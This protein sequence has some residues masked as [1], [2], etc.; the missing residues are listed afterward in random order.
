[1][2]KKKEPKTMGRPRIEIKYDEFEKLC[3]YQATLE[4]IASWFDCSVDTIELRVKEHY[5]DDEGKGRTFTDVFSSLRGKG[6]IALRRRQFQN[7]MKGS[8]KMLVHLGK[9]YLGQTEKSEVEHT[10][11]GPLVIMR[12]KKDKEVGDGD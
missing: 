10:V 7:A 3:Y 5:L 9:Q 8:D 4:E 11:K 1:M 6:K 12:S 2:G